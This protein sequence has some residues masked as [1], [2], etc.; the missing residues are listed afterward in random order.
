MSVH[1]Y[2]Q[3]ELDAALGAA[4]GGTV[5]Y[6]FEWHAT[7]TSPACG[8]A[9]PASPTLAAA[10]G[11]TSVSVSAP[12]ETRPSSPEAWSGS[13]AIAGVSV[14]V[15]ATD[16]LVEDAAHITPL[17]SWLRPKHSGACAAMLA[18]CAGDTGNQNEWVGSD[19]L[20]A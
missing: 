20:L 9:A 19:E 11:V 18:F 14:G 10:Y 17:T 4:M 5:P 2:S 12:V 15:S 6:P 16:V 8:T 3:A 13:V 7:V 1:V